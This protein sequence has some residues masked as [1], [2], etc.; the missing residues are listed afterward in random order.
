MTGNEDESSFCAM[1]DPVT[2]IST[3]SG[4]CFAGV[5]SAAIATKLI[6]EAP[7]PTAMPR[8]DPRTRSLKCNPTPDE[9]FPRDVWT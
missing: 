9:L 1:L 4:F 6:S 5:V 2:P 7:N 3:S 8:T